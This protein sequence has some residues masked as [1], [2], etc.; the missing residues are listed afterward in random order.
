ME[1]KDCFEILSI[2]L[3]CG[4]GT[5]FICSIIGYAIYSAFKLF[6]IK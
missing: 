1:I 6:K 2:G 5:S 4:F 3:A